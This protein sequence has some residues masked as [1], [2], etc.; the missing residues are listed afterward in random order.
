[1]ET[2]MHFRNTLIALILIG[3]IFCTTSVHAQ[4]TLTGM[5]RLTHTTTEI[6]GPQT[7]QSLTEVIATDEELRWQVYVPEHYQRQRPPGVFVFVDPN[8]WGG[9]PDELRPV[10]DQHNL[11]WI[12]ANTNERRPT[13][14]KRIWTSILASKALEGEYVID[15]NRLYVGSSGATA[16]TAVNVLMLANQHSGA[17]FFRGSQYWHGGQPEG[18]DNLRRKYFV[19]ITGTNDKAKTEIRKDYERYKKDGMEHSKL[20]FEMKSLGRTPSTAQMDEAIRYLD[21]RLTR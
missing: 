7:A 10:F 11:I 9:I 1:M 8:G 21:S 14:T 4:S 19:F 5:F 18:I 12:G 6:V 17:V 13:E 3:S 16:L 2:G 15:L 20:I